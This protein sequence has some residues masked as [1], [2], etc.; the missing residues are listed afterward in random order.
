MKNDSLRKCIRKKIKD[1]DY[2]GWEKIFD[3]NRGVQ[4]LPEMVESYSKID[5]SYYYQLVALY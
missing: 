2:S 3:K 1:N 5:P 4:N